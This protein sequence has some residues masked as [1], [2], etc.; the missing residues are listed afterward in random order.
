[1]LRHVQRDSL[2]VLKV[3]LLASADI[4]EKGYSKVRLESLD[5]GIGGIGESAVPGLQ[6]R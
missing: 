4:L 6:S 5:Q 2:V 1:M 3:Q